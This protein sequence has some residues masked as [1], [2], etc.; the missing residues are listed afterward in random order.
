MNPLFALSPSHP[1]VYSRFDIGHQFL[2]I[3]I[4]QFLLARPQSQRIVQRF[5]FGL[6]QV[7]VAVHQIRAAYKSSSSHCI[8]DR[9]SAVAR[10][11][12]RARWWL[13][14]TYAAL[15]DMQL[16]SPDRRRRSASPRTKKRSPTPEKKVLMHCN[17]FGC[18]CMHFATARPPA[19]G[20]P[21]PQR[22]PRAHFG[23]IWHLR[24]A[25]GS[26][27]AHCALPTSVQDACMTSSRTASRAPH[28]VLP[29]SSTSRLTTPH[30]LSIISTTARFGITAYDDARF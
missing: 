26:R 2:F 16:Q 18:Q 4:M 11:V 23:D 7:T 13:H 15:L 1:S 12:T 30:P 24:Q 25:Q 17:N 29:I 22:Q 6:L 28:V 3:I 5:I 8:E 27:H 19:R 14:L 21:D 10:H 9:P 20:P